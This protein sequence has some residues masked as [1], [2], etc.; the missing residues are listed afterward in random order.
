MNDL[1]KRKN[2]ALSLSS[3]GARGLAHVGAIEALEQYGYKI[4]SIAGTSCGALVAGIYAA[5]RLDAFKKWAE[6]LDH[7]KIRE[8]T[9]YALSLS[10]LVKGER[11]IEEL[12]KICPDR[13][14]E[15]LPIPFCCVATDWKTGEEVVFDCGSLW[16][17]IRASISI[18]AYLEPVEQDGKILIDGGISNPLPLDRV[19]RT[20]NDLLVGVNVSGHDYGSLYE[21]RKSTEA[22]LIKN[23]RVLTLLSKMIPEGIDPSLNYYTLLNQTISIAISQNARKSI[24]LNKPDLMLD[25]PMKRYNGSDYDKFENIRRVGF[26]KM[27]QAIEAFQKQQPA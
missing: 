10:Y 5:G 7:K 11:I 22:W 1:A 15:E 20:D 3:G 26:R 9:D 14:I 23:S 17:A 2:V 4:T 21:R 13:N 16:Q 19:V 6:Q 27:K 24:L 8:L 25:L 18:P 12:K